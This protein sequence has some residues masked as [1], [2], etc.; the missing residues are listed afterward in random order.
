MRKAKI[1]KRQ[2][3]LNGCWSNKWRDKACNLYEHCLR[4]HSAREISS[5]L[6]RVQDANW[7]QSQRIL[8]VLN[9]QT[10]RTNTRSAA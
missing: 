6:L 1:A 3:D 9:G 8:S 2:I 4:A 5:W 10:A 7:L